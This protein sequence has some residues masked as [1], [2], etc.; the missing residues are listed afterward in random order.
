MRQRASYL[1]ALALL[2][3]ETSGLQQEVYIF[4]V[5]MPGRRDFAYIGG[6]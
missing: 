3:N 1:F 6:S 2:S 5:K 4:F